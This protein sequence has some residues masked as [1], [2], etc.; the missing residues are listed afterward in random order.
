M[1]DVHQFSGC[2]F[3]IFFIQ[4]GFKRSWWRFLLEVLGRV[5]RC[6]VRGTWNMSMIWQLSGSKVVPPTNYK[7]VYKAQ[8]L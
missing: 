1:E 2:S 8:E 7:L 3:L 4:T 6:Y 5:E